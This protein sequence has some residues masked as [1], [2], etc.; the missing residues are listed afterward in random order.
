M[1]TINNLSSI[2]SLAGGDQFPVYDASNGDARKISA[3][4]VLAYVQ[5]N[6]AQPG[7]DK[8]TAA[9]TS[10]GFTVTVASSTEDQI[11]LVLSPTGTMATGTIAIPGSDDSFDGQSILVT[12][13]QAITSLS[14]SCPDTVNGAPAG[15][16]AD[17]FFALRFDADSDS[18]FC[19]GQSLGATSSFTNITVTNAVVDANGYETITFGQ[20]G[21]GTAVNN[22]AIFN[23][24]T[25]NGPGFAAVGSDTNID[26]DIVPK[27]SGVVL[28][29]GVQA[30]DLSSSQTLTNKTLDAA[31][32]NFNG[33]IRQSVY[34][35]GIT[36]P[37]A[38]VGLLGARAFVT[39]SSVTTFNNVVAGGGAN[40]VPVFCDGTDW[41]VG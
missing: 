6:F 37:A 33:Y 24:T 36:L 7:L 3:S 14:I 17:G 40:G 25:G 15:L 16:A 18:W 29:D 27:G 35:V 31:T 21:V 5:D 34:L 9:P 11:W 4:N 32:T 1:T 19:V 23:A 38:S 10:S 28:V 30:A 13:S 22:V 39:N 41:R 26:V 12:T 20:E 8:Q 2:D